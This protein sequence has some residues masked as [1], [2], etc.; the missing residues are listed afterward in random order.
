MLFVRSTSSINYMQPINIYGDGNTLNIYTQIKIIGTYLKLLAF[1]V[2]LNADYTFNAIP[3]SF[4][5]FEPQVAV[6]LIFFTLPL[7]TA[8]SFL[9]S[10]WEMASFFLLSLLVSMLPIMQIIKYPEIISERALFIPSMFFCLFLTYAMK[11][12]LFMSKNSFIA[13]LT[14]LAIIFSIR[15][16]SRNFDWKDSQRFWEKTVFTSPMS[17]RAHYNLGTIYA[18]ISRHQDAIIEFKK[19]LL[20]N[21]EEIITIPDY[22]TSSLLNLGNVYYLTRKYSDAIENYRNVLDIEPNNR[23][24]LKNIKLAESRIWAK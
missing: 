24:A 9:N 7:I 2:H 17:A 5:I 23:S 8:I 18:K 21:P 12:F 15:T 22:T 16:A 4:S 13:S 1:P 20:I 6:S 11:N 10:R 3:Q 14:L 19:S